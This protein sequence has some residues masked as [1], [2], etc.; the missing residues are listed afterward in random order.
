MA[1]SPRANSTWTPFVG[2]GKA[3]CLRR[4]SSRCPASTARWS[5][6]AATSA[7]PSTAS[8][9]FPNRSACRRGT[10]GRTYPVAHRDTLA[11]QAG[12]VVEEGPSVRYRGIF[13]NDEA[14]DLTNWV[15][16]K[17]G[18]V[19]P[20]ANPNVIPNV[21]N[22]GRE[23]YTKLFELMLRVRANYL[24]PAMWNNAFNE[25]DP[26]NAR[27]ADEY[28]IVMGT[29]H[30]EPMLRAQKEWIGA[31]R[32][33]SGAGTTRSTPRCSSSSGARASAGTNATRASSRWAC[34]AP[35][36]RRWRPAV[37]MPSRVARAH[38]RRATQDPARGSECR[39]H[40]GAA[41]VVPV[42]GGAGV[43]RARHACP[44]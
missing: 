44:R 29:S 28:G 10:G 19:S 34:V 8:T 3:F 36:T 2:S 26:E 7:A 5:S 35:T 6:P 41:D 32:R 16:A 11:W 21:A 9:K 20:Q 4:W 31:T 25:D 14:P 27:L 43:L 42:Q 37:P 33:R 13:L 24:W 30:Q 15:R 22:Y 18:N 23:F 12:R 38:R 40:A 1:W 39:H 17:F